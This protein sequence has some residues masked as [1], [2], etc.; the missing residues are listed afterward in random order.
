MISLLPVHS[1][2]ANSR[3]TL[4][5]RGASQSRLGDRHMASWQ[6]GD[7]EPWVANGA[8]SGPHLLICLKHQPLHV[9]VLLHDHPVLLDGQQAQPAAQVLQQ[10]PLPR[11]QGMSSHLQSTYMQHTSCSMRSLD[12]KHCGP[13]V[14]PCRTSMPGMNLFGVQQ[15]QPLDTPTHTLRVRQACM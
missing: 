14:T 9:Q 4:P 7:A 13:P 12:S 8:G 3:C 6:V 1:S 15:P 10:S 11:L 5:G 2:N